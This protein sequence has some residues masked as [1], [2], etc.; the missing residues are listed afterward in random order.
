MAMKQRKGRG[1]A[2]QN[3]SRKPCRKEKKAT[4]VEGKHKEKW[5]RRREVA[6]AVHVRHRGATWRQVPLRL[7]MEAHRKHKFL[8]LPSCVSSYSELKLIVLVAKE[9]RLIKATAA[10]SD[11]VRWEDARAFFRR[12]QRAT[13][14]LPGHT[15]PLFKQKGN[16][17]FNYHLL[18][19]SFFLEGETKG[20][21]TGLWELWL[22]KSFQFGTAGQFFYLC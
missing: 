1:P 7:R 3:S 10:S 16:R 13:R 8:V 21:R 19:A 22:H 5:E 4:Q 9:P 18:F 12:E 17:P 15:G 20:C 2:T 14:E 11:L 6:I